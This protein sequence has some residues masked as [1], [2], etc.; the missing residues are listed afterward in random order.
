MR[1]LQP[2]EQPVDRGIERRPVVE[3]AG[4]G[5]DRRGL[6]VETAEFARP[7]EIFLDD[8]DRPGELGLAGCGLS[9]ADKRER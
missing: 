9:A 6:P 2:G 7:V 8:L 5:A 1:G 4:S 3:I